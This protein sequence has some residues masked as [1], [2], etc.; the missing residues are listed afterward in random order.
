LL[1][2]IEN[3]LGRP[4]IDVKTYRDAFGFVIGAL[5]KS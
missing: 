3:R 5:I 1:V 4:I 2:K